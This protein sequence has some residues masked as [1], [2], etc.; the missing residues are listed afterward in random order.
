MVFGNPAGHGASR[1]DPRPKGQAG[2]LD[3]S[4]RG[5]DAGRTA[6]GRV[7][8]VP[9]DERTAHFTRPPSLG[10]RTFIPPCDDVLAPRWRMNPIRLSRS[11]ALPSTPGADTN[12]NGCRLGELRAARKAIDL[13]GRVE[14]TW[15]YPSQ[16]LIDRHIID[17]GALGMMTALSC[18]S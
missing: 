11:P 15:S 7:A 18:V 12:K 14:R 9:R 2:R 5:R 16:W 8:D 6:P 4:G 1:R 3:G 17:H 10:G 13:A